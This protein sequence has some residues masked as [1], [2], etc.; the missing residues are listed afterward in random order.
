MSIFVFPFPQPLAYIKPSHSFPLHFRTQKK[1][2]LELE[3][4]HFPISPPSFKAKLRNSLCFSCCFR[5][6]VLDSHTP[7]SL[8][9][10][11]VTSDDKPTVVWL[12]KKVSAG[13]DFKDEIKDKCMTVFNR[14]G[15]GNS[16]KLKRHSSAEFRYDPL[17]YSLNFEDGFDGDDEAPLR[18]FSS[19]LPPSPPVKAMTPAI[20]GITAVS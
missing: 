16:T 13:Q 15:N 14:I 18:N 1:M 8:S 7:S 5:R 6:Q 20:R 17:S 19:R 12:K 11:T 4:D 10:A 2:E 9:A 3:D